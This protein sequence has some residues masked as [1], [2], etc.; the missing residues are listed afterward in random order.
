METL[1]KE[2]ELPSAGM[3]GG[4]KKVTVRPMTTKEEKLIYTSRDN[5]F[6]EKIVKSCIV[7]PKDIN[8]SLLHA[9][10]ITYLLYMIR[11]MTFGPT[12]LQQAQCP[13]C[14]F[15]Q[16]IEIDITEMSYY[17]VDLETL[18]ESL[19]VALPVSGDVLK[20]QLINQGEMNEIAEYV[21]KLNRAGKLKDAEGYE[22]IYRFAKLVKTINGEEVDT[23]QVMEYLESLN[24][25][26]F[27][28]IKKSLADIKIGIDTTNIRECS[29]CKEEMEVSGVTVPEFFRSY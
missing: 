18:E 23:K 14:D 29:R 26:D 12:Y 17:I 1:T 19:T 5:T 11:E 27:S 16:D 9:A 15:K 2:F 3:F 20:L 4:P 28:E 7:E 22:Y 25:R 21:K 13:Y 6:I 10:D 8:T 24:L